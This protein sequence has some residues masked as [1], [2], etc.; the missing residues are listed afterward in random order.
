[1]YGDLYGIQ[2]SAAQPSRQRWVGLVAVIVACATLGLGTNVGRA[3]DAALTPLR[4]HHYQ[5]L[6]INQNT[7]VAYYTGI[8]KKHGLDVTLVPLPSG[9]AVEAAVHAGSVDI[10]SQDLDQTI[11]NTHLQNLNFTTICGA[12]GSYYQVV[13]RPGFK[14]EGPMTY[15]E[16]MKNF[17][18]KKLGVTALGADTFYFWEALFQAAGLSPDSGTY[19]GTGVGQQSLSA[20]QHGVVDATMG[21]EPLTTAEAQ[22]G[23][24][25]V[26]NL[27]KGDGPPETRNVSPQLIYFVDKSYLAS[28]TDAVTKFNDAI[29]EAVKFQNDPKNFDAVV[30][31]MK[32]AMGPL[33][34]TKG[35][36]QIVRDNIGPSSITAVTIESVQAWLK[37]TQ[38]FLK[39]PT[40]VTPEAIRKEVVWDK[41]CQ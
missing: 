39:F 32:Q 35:F 25:I 23:S 20:V 18:G 31:A 36:D 1:M 11:I 28:H 24:T 13:T 4:V 33:G 2:T 16:V 15:P 38:A 27:A 3:D 34:D 10:G 41:A 5:G 17:V 6:F 37:F 12:E 7:Y 9:P 14:F 30:G 21:F 26:L 22:S 40:D 29:L 8:F 19:I